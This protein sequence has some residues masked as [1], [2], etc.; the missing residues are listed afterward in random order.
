MI[1]APLQQS[2]VTSQGAGM[3]VPVWGGWYDDKPVIHH[4]STDYDDE[5][6][7][8]FTLTIFPSSA[9]LRVFSVW[10]QESFAT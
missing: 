8:S 2:T 7:C 1:A 9:H 4:L 5:Q 3:W 6:N 10:V